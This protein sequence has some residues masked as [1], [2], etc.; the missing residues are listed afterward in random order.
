MDDGALF[1][2]YENEYCQKSTEI[3]RQ[4]TGLAAL[5][6]GEGRG[7]SAC[8]RADADA[9]D[10]HAPPASLTPPPPPPP[11]QSSA[12]KSWPRSPRSSRT[13]TMW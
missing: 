7:V 12:G 3:S 5:T 9:N 10:R 4:I 13:P 2:Q 1:S 6:A 11:P 8:L